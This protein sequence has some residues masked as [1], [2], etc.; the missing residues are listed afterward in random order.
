MSTWQFT[1]KRKVDTNQSTVTSPPKRHKLQHEYK[2]LQVGDPKIS[3]SGVEDAQTLIFK[4][5][6][7]LFPGDIASKTMKQLYQDPCI[8]LGRLYSAFP[9]QLHSVLG[10]G[11]LT[12]PRTWREPTCWLYLPQGKVKIP[13]SRGR[14]NRPSASQG[15]KICPVYVHPALRSSIILT[16]QQGFQLM[17]D[18]WI[19]T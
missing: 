3:L 9:L 17:F 16:I 1:Q 8:V 7:L 13:F 5:C 4:I 18:E 2:Y 14:L 11:N 10:R 6:C 19:V 15:I 12:S